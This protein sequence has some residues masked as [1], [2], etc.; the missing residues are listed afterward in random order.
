MPHLPK[1]SKRVGIITH[2]ERIS[3]VAS[4]AD[5]ML[6]RIP[7][8]STG[9][10]LSFDCNYGLDQAPSDDLNLQYILAAYD[11]D[12]S[13]DASSL[14]DGSLWQAIQHWEILS[15]VGAVQ[16]LEREKTFFFGRSF[17]N[18]SIAQRTRNYG[19]AFA[20]RHNT[21]VTSLASLNL[22]VQIDYIIRTYG[23]D[24]ATFTDFD[25]PNSEGLFA[26]DMWVS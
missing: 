10:P 9:T 19:F 24:M 23:N 22:I 17:P 20:Q 18:I 26:E 1:I 7:P 3:V 15:S 5:T 12:N 16:T 21:S 11:I 13:P 2:G 8:N 4:T 14:R 25:T 6:I